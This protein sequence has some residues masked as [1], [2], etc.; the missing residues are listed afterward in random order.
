MTI[1]IWPNSR[2]A[3]WLPKRR[4]P[5]STWCLLRLG[6]LQRCCRR[7]QRCGSQ[8]VA[9]FGPCLARLASSEFLGAEILPFS[10]IPVGSS[11][12]LLAVP[13]GN[14]FN[15]PCKNF[16]DAKNLWCLECTNATG[17]RKTPCMSGGKRLV[18]PLNDFLVD[19][20]PDG[21]VVHKILLVVML[22]FKQFGKKS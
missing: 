21:N 14:C 4:Q 16:G 22:L 9:K 5:Y 7:L 15:A 1:G 11:A 18:M 17:V 8:C 10:K 20:K 12:G 6:F 19:S 3:E 13:V 2:R